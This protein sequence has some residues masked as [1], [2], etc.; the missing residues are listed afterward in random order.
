LNIASCPY[1]NFY[2]REWSYTFVGVEM[3]DDFLNILRRI[4]NVE[5]EKILFEGEGWKYFKVSV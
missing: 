3:G 1:K 2:R 5:V 4:L